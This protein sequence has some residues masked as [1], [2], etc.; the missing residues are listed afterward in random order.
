MTASHNELIFKYDN[1]DSGDNNHVFLLYLSVSHFH[2]LVHLIL[3][4][5]A[6]EG[7]SSQQFQVVGTGC[8]CRV[9][10]MSFS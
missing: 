5:D 9:V 8:C 7:N 3:T 1:D 10:C 6:V 2:T 4:S